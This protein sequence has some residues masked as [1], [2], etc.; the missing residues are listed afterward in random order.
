M[1]QAW[2]TSV[3]YALIEQARNRFA[4]GLLLLFV[5]VWDWLFGALIPATPVAFKLQS[6]GDYLQVNGHDLTVLTSGFNAITLIVA[7]MI[8]TAARRNAAFDRRLVLA[9]LPQPVAMAAKT[10]AIVVVATLVSL[11]ASVVLEAFWHPAAFGA[12][13]LGYLLDALTYGALGLLLGVLVSSELAGFFL[14][15]MVSLLDTTLQAPVENPLANK[16]FLAAF[17]SYGPIQVAVS[18]GVGHGVPGGG[19]LLA[20]G[21]FIGFA[22]VGLLIFWWR[23]RAWNA[24]AR[25]RAGADVPTPA[26]AIGV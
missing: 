15:I 19:I 12:V 9:G 26:P 20:L 25:S 13:W 5:P 6:T 14:I 18:G 2:L 10:A 7:F 22:F 3:R 8:F 11:Y 16:D 23:T 4:L 21:W 24:Q 17:P 1:F